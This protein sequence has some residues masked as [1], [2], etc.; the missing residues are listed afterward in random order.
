MSGTKES[1]L[2]IVV[3]Y[4]T[5]G[6]FIAFGMPPL[7]NFGSWMLSVRPIVDHR[8]SFER[9]ALNSL[10]IHMVPLFWR[11]DAFWRR[12]PVAAHFMNVT[13]RMMATAAIAFVSA[14]TKW[15][16]YIFFCISLVG[17][18][19]SF[20]ALESLFSFGRTRNLSS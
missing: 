6:M 10:W 12:F 15:N 18:Y 14:A 9:C 8:L 4:L 7:W 16:D 5:L 17:C 3:S 20:V 11:S 19:F 2:W 1:L 13:W